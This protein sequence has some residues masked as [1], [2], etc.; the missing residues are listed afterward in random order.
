MAEKFKIGFIGLGHMGMAMARRL[1]SAGYDVTA[2]NRTEAKTRSLQ[3]AT[4][5]K[6][7]AEVG[8]SCNFIFTMLA[9]D[10]AVNEVVNG[11]QG[12]A[13]QMKK[14]ATHIAS[15]TI[16][17]E[18]S[19][20]LARQHAEDG[21][22]YL[23][24]P[25]LGRPDAAEAGKLFVL[26]SGA[27]TPVTDSL[28]TVIGQKTFVIPG[29][30]ANAHLMKLA[31]N[32]MQ[33]SAIETM[34]EGFSLVRKGGIESGIFYEIFSSTLFT[35]P[36]YKNYGALIAQEKYGSEHGFKMTLA[37]KDLHLVLTSA[38]E[39]NISLPIASVVFERMT[40]ALSKGYTDLDWSALGKIAAENA[41]LPGCRSAEGKN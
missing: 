17:V 15:S 8:S 10:V 11:P 14:G 36:A 21:Q 12:F 26:S 31:M 24:A 5:A 37:A 1:V 40:E 2:Y 6:T 32:F 7:P 19:R 3:G 38:Q 34:A 39:M 9:D 30:P 16:S 20:R 35:A 29:D 22:F 25:V 13:K 27:R 4:V 33:A 23:A 41:R 18:L 28:L